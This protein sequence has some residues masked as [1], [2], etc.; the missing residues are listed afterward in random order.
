MGIITSHVI[1][2]IL[3]YLICMSKVEGIDLSRVPLKIW[4]SLPYC[5]VKAVSDV[6]T[7]AKTE[8]SCPQVVAIELTCCCC[9]LNKNS[10]TC[11]IV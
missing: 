11:I 6:E 8:F 1:R 3:T 4:I 9:E 7:Q 5:F 2:F 10:I